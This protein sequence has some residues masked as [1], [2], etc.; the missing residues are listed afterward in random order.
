MKLLSSTIEGDILREAADQINNR[1]RIYV[2]E[3][4]AGVTNVYYGEPEDLLLL[5]Q[6][7]GV[8]KTSRRFEQ[9]LK[10]R[11]L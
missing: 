9:I 3:T 5:G 7:V 1:F 11:G 6:A 4:H 8:I 10:E 2:A